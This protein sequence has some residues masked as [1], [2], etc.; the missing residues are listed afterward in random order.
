MIRVENLLYR[1]DV[2]KVPVL[3][4]LSLAIEE[5]E[6][7]AVIGPNGCGKTTLIK[8]LNGLLLPTEGDV[9]VDGLNT[10]DSAALPEI[11]QNVGMIFQN[12]D[13][14]I[15]GMTVEED[16]AFGPGNLGLPPAE[17]GR[18]VEA[19]LETVGMK[20]FAERPPHSL[21]GGEKQLVSIAGILA[22]NPHYIAFDEPTS[23]LDPF[24]QKRVLRVIKALN[25]QG[26]TI[27]HITHDMDEIIG[28]DRVIVM[29]EGSILL[30]ET[31]PV[32]FTERERLKQLGLDVPRAAE[33]LWRLRQLGA[34]VR[35]DVLS[36]DD[37]CREVFSLIKGKAS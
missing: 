29:N 24:G 16:V 18:R 20:A 28:A 21:S 15:V 36:L 23:H 12:P 17:I 33:L 4:G 7:V 37:A 9:L 2:Q 31:P 5:G 6:Y 26:I 3:Q 22:M 11:R 32:V 13:N 14:Q 10:R 1:Y 30:E 34:D 27:I 25:E 19:S 35:P 8:H